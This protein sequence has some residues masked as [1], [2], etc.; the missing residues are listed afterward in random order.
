MGLMQKLRSSTKYIIWLLII[1]FGLLWVLADTQVF[2]AMMAGPRNMGEVNSETVTYA[3]FNQRVNMFTEQHREQTGGSPDSEVRAQYEE[4]AWEQ[5]IVDKILKQKMNDMGIMVT[6]SELVDMV[7]GDNPD[8]FIRQQFTREDGTI[9]RV[10]LQNAIESPENREIWIM[11]E[12]Q[13]REQRRQQKLNQYLEASLRVSDFEIQQHYKKENSHADFRYVRFPYSDVSSDEI[14]V[15]DSEIRNF[16]NNNEHR[17]QRNKSWRFSYVTFSIAPTPEDTM[18]VINRLADLRD[19]FRQADDTERFLR[20]NYSETSYFDSFLRPDEVRREHLR[21]FEL[22]LDEVSEPYVYNNRVHMVRLL[23][24]RPSDQTYV[25]VRQIRL[26]DNEQDRELADEIVNRAREGESFAELARTYSR[27]SASANRGGEVGY[28]ARDDRPAALAN[29]IFAAD[30]GSI[31]GPVDGDDGVYLFEVVNRTNRDIRFADLSRD[32]E[33]DPFETVQRLANEAEDFQYFAE[34]DGF[35]DEAERSGYTVEEGV[36]TEGNPF[37]SGLGQSRIIL[38]ELAPLRRGDISDVIETEDM[39][40]VFRVEEVIPEGTRPLEEVRSQVESLVRDR[41]RKEVLTQRVSEM[42]DGSATLEELAEQS[43]REIREVDRI[44][45]SSST[46]PGV[47]R[48]PKLVGAAFALPEGERSPA[49][50]G[51]NAV[52]VLVVDSRTMADPTA[53]TS[54]DRREIRER[55]QQQKNS[56]F[57]EVWVDRLKSG[58]DIRDFRTQQRMMQP[59]APPM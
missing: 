34:S 35:R 52:F 27:H 16:Y 1:S 58:A 14:E 19:D 56:A 55:L 5:L 29:A 54:A 21:A 53:I 2:D 50:D 20:Q 40:I 33:A 17:F 49:I 39:F 47:G 30:P 51:N 44:R 13:L 15:T 45:L 32:V 37:I 25:R 46:V 36:A 18:R 59:Q 43:G 10:A 48:E 31:V 24:E 42:L 38:N 22:D 23:E 41:N 57:S 6:D 12:Q 11:I 3:E 28:L 7:T 4:M 8:P 9:D 26:R